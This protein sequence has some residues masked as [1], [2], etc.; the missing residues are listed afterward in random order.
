LVYFQALP[1][2]SR[3]RFQKLREKAENVMLTSFERCH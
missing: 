1:A 2:K 3:R